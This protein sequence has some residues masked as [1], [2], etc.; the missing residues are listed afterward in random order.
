MVQRVNRTNN[1]LG[2]IGSPRKKGNT[3]V[4]VCTILD[5][6][7]AEGS[8]IETI[9]FGDLDIPECDGCYSCWKGQDP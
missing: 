8:D 4:L 9:F 2:V 7:K 3:H 5:G 6:A 1:I